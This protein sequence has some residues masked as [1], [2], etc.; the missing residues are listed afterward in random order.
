MGAKYLVLLCMDTALL[1][2]IFVH[3]GAKIVV[4][5]HDVLVIIAHECEVFFN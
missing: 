1:I 2:V 4:Y 5:G 3:M